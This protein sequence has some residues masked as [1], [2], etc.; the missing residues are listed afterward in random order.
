MARILENKTIFDNLGEILRGEEEEFRD[1]NQ[2]QPINS[3]VTGDWLVPLLVRAL[4][5]GIAC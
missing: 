4:G 5:I 2:I 1:G 3:V